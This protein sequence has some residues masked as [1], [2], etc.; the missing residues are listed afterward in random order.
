MILAD[1]IGFSGTHSISEILSSIPSAHVSHG[2]KNFDT[3]TPIGIN[4]VSA[5][6][7]AEQMVA[8]NEVG[9]DCFAIHS[10]FP[11]AIMMSEAIKN[12]IDYKVIVRNPIDQ[13]RS[14][15]AWITTKILSGDP[16]GFT[17]VIG[18][19][20]SFVAQVGVVPNLS[21]SMY[22]FAI[23]HCTEFAL[24]ALLMDAPLIK[25]E[26]VL[27]DE[28]KF[29]EAFGIQPDTELSH[30]S[31]GAPRRVS[32]RGKTKGLV[33]SDPEEDKLLGA[34]T[35]NIKGVGYSFEEFSNLLGYK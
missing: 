27:S 17:A 8:M 11:P 23:S 34:I 18:S 35:L 33:L 13:I 7:F 3:C 6:D 19:R 32:H 20:Q 2:S 25:M 12:D 26:D 24:Q 15:Y 16:H 30:F 29:R 21:N 9:K 22:A 14:C 10:V 28:I 31:N 4:D 1:S 5:K